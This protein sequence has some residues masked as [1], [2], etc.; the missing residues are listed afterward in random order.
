MSFLITK[1][2]EML[3]KQTHCQVSVGQHSPRGYENITNLPSLIFAGARK[4]AE[5]R[6]VKALQIGRSTAKRMQCRL[7]AFKQRKI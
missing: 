4:E 3:F 6:L 7:Q 2:L 1:I 5:K